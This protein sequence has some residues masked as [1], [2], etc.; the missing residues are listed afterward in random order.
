MGF[1]KKLFEKKECA[2][3]GG[4]I[5]LLGN[6]KLEDGNMCKNCAAKLSPWFSDRRESSVAQ[7][8]AQ[9]QYREENQ[10]KLN[11]LHVSRTIGEYYKV[12]VE[13]VNGV[14]ERFVVCRDNDY[15]E[16]NADIIRF[17]DVSSCTI[18]IKEHKDELE[19]RND[20]NELVSYD[21]PRYRYQ[22]DFYV[23][24]AIENNPYF[25]EIEFKLNRDSVDIETE[26]FARKARTGIGQF[27]LNMVEFDPENYAEYRE[28]KKMCDELETIFERG[29]NGTADA[30]EADS[31]APAPEQD[32]QSKPKFCPECGAPVSGG[33]FCEHCGTRL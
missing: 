24:L 5:G 12:F 4:E 19:Y 2:I 18:D 26:D 23:E 3:C 32:A 22:Y 8:E 25:S 14:P 27:L 16:A 6:R 13:E 33:K 28:Y 17:Q 10:A 7:I 9:L 11:D 1:F 31:P 30:G 15:R 21:P 29:K 20:Q